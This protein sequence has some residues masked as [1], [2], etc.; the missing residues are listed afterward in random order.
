[1]IFG[2]N[3]LKKSISDQNEKSEYH[4]WILLIWISLVIK[5][6]LWFQFWFFRLNLPKKGISGLIQKNHTFA[7]T[8]GRY[9][10][11]WIFRTGDD[12]HSSILMSLLLLVAETINKIYLELTMGIFCKHIKGF[13][14]TGVYMYTWWKSRYKVLLHVFVDMFLIQ[15]Y[16]ISIYITQWW[17]Q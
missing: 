12:R 3:L 7:C 9:L 5:F 14:Q 16:I 15:I 17:Q 13:D 2:T 1:M 10:L 8:H 6:Q 11:C 4:H